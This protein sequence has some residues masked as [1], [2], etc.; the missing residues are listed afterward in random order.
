MGDEVIWPTRQ[1]LYHFRLEHRLSHD[2]TTGATRKIHW[3]QNTQTD[4]LTPRGV[5][6]GNLVVAKDRLLIATSDMLYAFRRYPT[7]EGRVTTTGCETASGNL[8]LRL[9][10]HS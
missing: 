2:A 7:K 8:R 1:E 5:T 3:W 4:N 9:R 6:G 10:S